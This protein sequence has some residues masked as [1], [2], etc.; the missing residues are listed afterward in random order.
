MKD[1]NENPWREEPVIER[2]GY[3]LRSNEEARSEWRTA[4]IVSAIV[5]VL[6]VIAADSLGS[7]AQPTAPGIEI[8][9][10]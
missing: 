10:K 5:I 3:Q 6:T 8:Q 2:E 9:S 1:K 4:L 7:K